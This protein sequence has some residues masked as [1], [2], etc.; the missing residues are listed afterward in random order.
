MDVQR[1]EQPAALPP[2]A[3]D[4]NKG[5]FGRVLIVGGNEEMIGAPVL[6][7]M[8]ALRVGAGGG[9]V[10]LSGVDGDGVG[11]AGGRAAGGGGGEGGRGGGGAG[12]GDGGGGEG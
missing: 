10:G 12:A 3:A 9:A 7:G 2:R 1:V 4:G 11:R 8:A 5:T 6:A